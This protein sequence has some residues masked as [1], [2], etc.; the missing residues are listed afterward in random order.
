MENE[1]KS[2]ITGGACTPY[3]VK[4]G[5]QYYQCV[6]TKSIFTPTT[7][8]QANMVGGTGEMQ[9]NSEQNAMRISRIKGLISNPAVLDYGCGNGLL[10]KDM[11]YAGL[12]A[13]GYDPY[14]EIY[15]T[16]PKH[17]FDVVAMIEVIEHTAYPFTELDQI[18]FLLKPGGVLYIETSFS[19]WV[20]TK[21][22]YLNPLIGHCT[23]FSHAG[24]DAV[25]RKKGFQRMTPI[26][27]NTRLYRKPAA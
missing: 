19:N 12:L 18:F 8:N 25:T 6:D 7:L 23:V 2:P 20:D 13:E 11:Q 5:V 24:L 4:E 1:V 15:G 10:L 26:D 16:K 9:R 3:C 21:H 14:S 22:P 27:G 17:Q